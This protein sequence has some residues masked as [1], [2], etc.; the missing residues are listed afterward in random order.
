V[1]SEG[2]VAVGI[3]LFIGLEREHRHVEEGEPKATILGVRTFAL[4]ALSGWLAA[5]LQPFWP[6]VPPVI[7]SL[8]GLLV[9]GQYLLSAPQHGFGLT[10]EIAALLTVGYGALVHFQMHLAVALGLMT[11]LILISK[12][13]VRVVLPQLLRVELTAVLQFL[14]VVAIVLPLLPTEPLDPW[15]V[16]PP[17]RIGMFVLFIASISFVGYVLTRLLGRSRAAGLTG[18]VGGLASSTAVTASSSQ[19]VG[20]EPALQKVAEVTVF[21]A[22]AVM[23]LRVLVVTAVIS[24]PMALSLLAPLGAMAVVLLAAAVLAAR[25]TRGKA[26]GGKGEELAVRNPFALLPALKWGAFLCAVLLISHFA[27]EKA[28]SAGLLLTAGLAGLSDVD[29]IT[30]ASSR[31]VADGTLGQGTAQLAI[32]LAVLSNT[33]VKAVIARLSGG[34]SFGVQVARVFGAAMVVAV[35]MALLV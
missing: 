8:L 4:L 15:G 31:Q 34:S 33:V 24:R 18:L 3:G 17:R 2:A 26:V 23:C 11:T 21:T 7:L 14:I 27:Q 30:L 13:W 19:Q 25:A 22:N 16:L 28:G 29:A 9:L 6:W 10:T 5:L 1:L 35:I 12:P 32:T 20:R